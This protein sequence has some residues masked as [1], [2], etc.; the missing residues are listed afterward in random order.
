MMKLPL[1]DVASLAARSHIGPMTDDIDDEATL[2]L[3]TLS[4]LLAMLDPEA[5]P[6]DECSAAV[7][8]ALD[9]VVTKDGRTFV[10]V[11]KLREILAG[12]VE[13]ARALLPEQPPEAEREI[14]SAFEAI[15]DDVDRLTRPKA[16][17]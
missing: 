9:P 2:R 3:A 11:G 15:A 12:A 1:C 17:H 8:A 7:L 14:D 6:P 4:L 13:E 16:Q 10:D 5:P